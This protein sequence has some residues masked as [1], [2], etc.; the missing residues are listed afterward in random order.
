[1]PIPNFRRNQLSLF[2]WLLRLRHHFRLDPIGVG[3]VHRLLW[4]N[5]RKLEP[6]HGSKLLLDNRCSDRVMMFKH[7]MHVSLLR[8]CNQEK[9]A[10]WRAQPDFNGATG[11]GF[12]SPLMTLYDHD[13]T[14]FP[15][16]DHGCV[17]WLANFLASSSVAPRSISYKSACCILD[18]SV[19][20]FR[21]SACVYN[22][23]INSISFSERCARLA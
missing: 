20:A 3:N 18:F 21:P 1:M 8:L 5:L 15:S 2:N 6:G 11:H 16:I 13:T 9:P 12:D 19:V 4:R 10:D 23:N 14:P 17:L 7:R 22:A